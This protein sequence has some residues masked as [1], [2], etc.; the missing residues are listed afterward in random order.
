MKKVMHILF[1]CALVFAISLSAV[2]QGLEES[3][4]KYDKSG[5]VKSVEFTKSD[6]NRMSVEVFFR[7]VLKIKTNNEFVRNEEIRLEKGNES[8]EQFYKGIKVDKA[9]YT[10]HYDENGCMKYA[11]GKYV[12]ILDLDTK[13]TIRKEDAAKAFAKFKG[14]SL[15]SITQSSAEL[16][17]KCVKGDDD[18]EI[19]ILVYKVSIAV[20]NVCITDYGYVDAKTG[21]VVCSESYINNS[22]AT[23]TFVTKYYGTKYAT[24]DL[25]NGSYYLY[26]PTRGD[27]IE[28]KDLQNY[29][30]TLK[31][32]ASLAQS[33]SDSDNYWQY[34]DYNDSTFMAYD[35][36]WAFQK[37]YD[38]LYF[39]HGKNSLN[40]NG[41]KIMAYVRA[42]FPLFFMVFTTSQAAWNQERKE[43]Y[44]GMGGGMNRPFSSMDIV[45]HEYGHGITYYQVG[46]SSNEQY[47]NEGLSDIWAIIMDYRFGDSNSLVWKMGEHIHPSKVCFRD[48]EF[49]ESDNAYEK[50][51]STYHS[52]LY[53]SLSAAG[54]NYGMSGVFSHWFYLLVNGGQSYNAN[55]TYYHLNPVGMDV[56][57]NL[58]VKAVYDNYLRNTTSY[59]DVRDAFIAAARAMNVYGL[60]VAV[61]NAWYAAG[62]GDM[63]YPIT[64]PDVV[65]SQGT[66][67]IDGLPSE[68]SVSWSL[69]G[70]NASNFIVQNNTPSTNQCTIIRQ[71]HT[72]FSG[73]PTL[74]LSAQIYI[75]GTAVATLT[76]SIYVPFIS[77]ETNPCLTDVY[78]VEGLSN[79]Y[80]V[81]W[82]LSGSGYSVIQD[83]I[84]N[85]NTENNNYL[86]VQRTSAQSY[87][88]GT[89]T[90]TL[91]N[92]NN[93]VE[94][95]T[96]DITSADGFVG[97]WFQSSSLSAPYIPDSIPE[98]LECRLHSVTL[99]KQIV[100]QSD[101]FIG[102]TITG[103]T[104]ISHN[105]NIVSF[106]ASSSGTIYTI[107]GYK[108]G[109][110]DAYRFRFLATTNPIIPM[111]LNINSTG[112]NY[113]FSVHQLQDDQKSSGSEI[114]EWKLTIV[115]SQTG[116]TMY[117][118]MAEGKLLTVN[119]SGWKPGVYIAIATAN[120][121]TITRKLAIID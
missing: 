15:D 59:S 19:P 9:G 17:I 82:D 12:D 33:I 103:N 3:I 91:L 52:V 58:I 100:L 114:E 57:E 5:N 121:C 25:S 64:G 71:E 10:F 93:A 66:Y 108:Q 86:G 60:D 83:F 63:Y 35:V 75:G 101:D 92:G 97:T 112:R 95:L 80:T 30:Y 42:S 118:G 73:S 23:G 119:T 113:T 102:A 115:Q 51:A 6:G 65:Y 94:T 21:N 84:P 8:F 34:S 13:P 38:R 98:V 62:V 1:A 22:A 47:L 54:K 46:W 50:M 14:L 45:A 28:V 31:S 85:Y 90:A 26:D 79:N 74:T 61:S 43:F 55:N 49:P 44:F 18:I 69:I 53:D 24:T 104:T 109:T 72:E 89:I 68:Y 27:G 116:Q 88:N 117:N 40:N 11:H 39:V 4:F 78:T 106:C 105:Y 70:D 107:Q 48:V 87:A 20:N 2:A 77:G 41:K 76:K 96:K 7:D 16:I 99:G 37:I 36:H 110:C 120:G 111:D 56:A 81:S 29:D 32:Y 67:N